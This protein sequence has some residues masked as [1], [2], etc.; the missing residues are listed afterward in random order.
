MWGRVFWQKL[1]LWFIRVLRDKRPDKGYYV[2][3]S[4]DFYTYSV[5]C[6]F[7]GFLLVGFKGIIRIAIITGV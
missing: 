6:G 2:N 5:C 7:A 1:M 3:R 4:S